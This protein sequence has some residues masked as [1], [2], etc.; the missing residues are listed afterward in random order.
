M[1]YS[2]WDLPLLISHF[3]RML[4]IVL[5]WVRDCRGLGEWRLGWLRFA[6]T[7]ERCARAPAAPLRSR[8][9]TASRPPWRKPS[10]TSTLAPYRP[11]IYTVKLRSEQKERNNRDLFRLLRVNRNP[12]DLN[13]SQ[14]PPANDRSR[15]P[16]NWTQDRITANVQLVSLRLN[17][18]Q[19]H[20]KP[21][22][23]DFYVRQTDSF[24]M[25]DKL[26]FYYTP[27]CWK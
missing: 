21:Q 23:G 22:Q 3:R 7:S 11:H 25:E 13:F 8:T 10:K 5:P 9:G 26:L 15:A 6:M 27:V 19:V 1:P 24:S 12:G 2:H 18:S 17:N 20:V 16:W 4:A 14:P